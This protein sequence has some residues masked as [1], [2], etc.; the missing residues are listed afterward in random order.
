[1]LEYT[2]EYELLYLYRQNDEE[3]QQ[4]MVN[5]YHRLIWS[6]VYKFQGAI[7]YMGIS[8]DDLFQEGMLGL[9]EALD[10]YREELKVPFKNF[11]C[12]CAER[13]MRSLIRKHSGQNYGIIANSISLDQSLVSE[14]TLMIKDTIASDDTSSDPV[15]SFYYRYNI[16]QLKEKMK[17]FSELEKQVMQY[18]Y[19]GY[20]YKEIAQKCDVN[21]KLVDNTI[22]KLKRKV[23]CLFD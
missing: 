18:R 4:M 12:L 6:I 13:Q 1:M 19:L 14:D 20:T 22:Q 9:L 16:E 5:Q 11:A 2:N 23:V 15:W 10:C 21:F 17:D 3:A 7:H 8:K